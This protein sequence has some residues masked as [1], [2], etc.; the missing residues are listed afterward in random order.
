MSIY[1]KK[2]LKLTVLKTIRTIIL[3]SVLSA[4]CNRSQED[5]DAMIIKE[6]SNQ[7][8]E[9]VPS[10][11][12]ELT[13]LIGDEIDYELATILHNGRIFEKEL[14]SNLLVLNRQQLVARDTLPVPKDIFSP[15]SSFLLLLGNKK[16]ND[17]I[18]SGIDADYFVEISLEKNSY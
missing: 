7:T 15:G 17:S 9:V 8:L 1:S 4:G 13:L 14:K 16:G 12:G 11:K 3:L 5:F 6:Y 18:H 2:K 10:V